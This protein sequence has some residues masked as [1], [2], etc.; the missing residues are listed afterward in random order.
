MTGYGW[1][2]IDAPR[3]LRST[4]QA[5]RAGSGDPTTRLGDGTF[6]HATLT[7]DGPGTLLLRWHT[8]PGPHDACGLQADAWGPGASWLLD[9][10]HRLTGTHDAP[11]QFPAGHPVVVRALN[12]TRTRRIGAS[13]NLYHH[14]LPN[15]LA[16]RIT[17]AEAVRQ[18]A[19][20]CRALG[21][22]APGP[23]EI[24]GPLR[25]PPSPASLV[26]RPAW[27]FHPLG[28]ESKRARALTEV[29]R[30][31]ERLWSWAAQPPEAAAGMLTL[32]PGIGPWTA[33]SAI[34]PALGDPDAVPVGDFHFPHA[35]AWAL[36][37]EPRADDARMLE[38][39]APYRGQRGRV[40]AAILRT[41]GGAPAF[42]PRRR[43]LPVA[44]L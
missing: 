14:L 26:R 43:T 12:S 42:G 36:A 41:E 7:P 20:L 25:L 3:S 23:P 34:G 30:H 6:L 17:G 1:E 32:L 40:L 11:V 33:G 44:R 9:G 10:V 13:G 29:A 16:Q 27:W 28:V 37:G 8:D 5:Q 2:T 31:A 35:V 22:P 18:W 38:L 21:D 15:V 19:A 24:V 39:L 4:L